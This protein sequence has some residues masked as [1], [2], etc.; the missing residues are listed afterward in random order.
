VD[1]KLLLRTNKASEWITSWDRGAVDTNIKG[2]L[3]RGQ[4]RLEE[5]LSQDD[6]P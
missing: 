4:T 2:M 5:A 6:P 3:I 1:I